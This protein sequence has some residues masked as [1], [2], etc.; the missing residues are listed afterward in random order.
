MKRIIK[1]L[2]GALLVVILAG[3]ILFVVGLAFTAGWIGMRKI[4]AIERINDLP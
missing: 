1:I 3:M 2:E 4:Q